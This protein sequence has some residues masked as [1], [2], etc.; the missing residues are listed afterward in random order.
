MP[1]CSMRQFLTDLLSS[2]YLLSSFYARLRSG[3]LRPTKWQARSHG[4]LFALVVLLMLSGTMLGWQG[5]NILATSIVRNYLLQTDVIFTPGPE[6]ASAH[7]KVHNTAD[8]VSTNFDPASGRLLISSSA[9]VHLTPQSLMFSATATTS[10]NPSL[11]TSHMDT[12]S[13]LQFLRLASTLLSRL[14]VHRRMEIWMFLRCIER[15]ELVGIKKVPGLDRWGVL[16]SMD[17]LVILIVLLP[18]LVG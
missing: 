4:S 17:M 5:R 11:L 7:T 2:R 6:R 10:T 13:R 14:L 3:L 8:Q 18:S 9:P 16:S 1:R 12:G 15:M